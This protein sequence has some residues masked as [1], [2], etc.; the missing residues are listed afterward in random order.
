MDISVIIVNWNSAEYTR[1]CI[2]SIRENTQ[3]ISYEIIVVDNASTDDSVECL[4]SIGGIRFIRSESNLGF[5]QANNLGAGMSSGMVILFLNP[6]TELVGPAI[7]RM[8]KAL[9]PSNFAAVGCKL[10]NADRTLQTTCIQPFPT[11][12]NQITDVEKLKLMFPQIPWWG[13]APLFAPME[14]YPARV[15]ALSGACIMIKREAFIQVGQ[16]STDYFMYAEDID[17]CYKIHQAGKAVGYL[18]DATIIHFGGQSTKKQKNTGFGDIATREAVFTF[19][20]KNH[21]T[22]YARTYRALLGLV[23][24]LRVVILKVLLLMPF[25]LGNQEYLNSA[26]QKW[27][28]ILRWSIGL[29]RWTKKLKPLG[30]NGVGEIQS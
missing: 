4:R 25:T 19:L 30:H 13:I 24:V 6:D 5:A 8:F 29:E 10:L 18:P 1:R 2:S 17:L 7:N 9:V 16:F 3:G 11:I 15:E 14:G 27:L 26:N 23:S 12:W 28:R 21:G 20:K 22:L